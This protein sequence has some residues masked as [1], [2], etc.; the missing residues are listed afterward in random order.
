MVSKR[1][2]R[3]NTI[4]QSIKKRV[5][6]LYSLDSRMDVNLRF[7]SPV[8]TYPKARVKGTDGR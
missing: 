7:E 4:F 6:I 3:R 8:K 2:D 1:V 5:W